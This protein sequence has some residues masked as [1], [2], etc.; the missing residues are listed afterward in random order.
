MKLDFVAMSAHE[1]RTPLTAVRG[2]LSILIE[3]MPTKLDKEQQDWVRKAFVSTSNLAAL[4]ENLLSISRIEGRNLKLEF[5]QSDWQEVLQ[6]L[7]DWPVV[8][9]ENL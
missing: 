6:R 3:E 2:Y 4:V 9:G 7:K 1:L 8:S 5:V